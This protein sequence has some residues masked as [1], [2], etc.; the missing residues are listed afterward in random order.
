[1]S[2]PT[3][4][5]LFDK[6]YTGSKG[7]LRLRLDPDYRVYLVT[8]GRGTVEGSRAGIAFME[9]I[10][11]EHPGRAFVCI[12]DLSQLGGSPIRVQFIL[13]NWL[14][15]RRDCFAKGALFGAN[16]WE[17]RLGT[18]ALKIARL[19]DRVSFKRTETDARAFLG[20]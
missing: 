16:P 19:T 6:T 13:G 9:E 15:G 20:W 10:I 18:V 11:A 3:P 4:D 2:E 12:G 5:F 7:W 17:R 1:M 14:L 8:A